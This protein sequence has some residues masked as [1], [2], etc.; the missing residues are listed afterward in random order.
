AGTQISQESLKLAW[1][2]FS[3]SDADIVIGSKRHLLSKVN[4]PLKR[5]IYSVICQIAAL[6]AFNLKVKDTQVGLKIYK[7]EIL[8]K[9]IPKMKTQGYAIDIEMLIAAGACG[10]KRIFETPVDLSAYQ[11][12]GA[13]NYKAV[14]QVARDMLRT[15]FR[16]LRGYYG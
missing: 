13:V 4:Y 16:L 7:K 14:F 1:R 8:N 3:F 6:I 9:I 15:Y 5:R 11:F 2:I 10:Y 12:G